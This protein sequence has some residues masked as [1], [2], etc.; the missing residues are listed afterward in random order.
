MRATIRFFAERLLNDVSP[1]H[2]EH[3][4]NSRSRDARRLLLIPRGSEDFERDMY[5]K[6]GYSSVEIDAS[7]SKSTEGDPAAA[8]A[9]SARDVVLPCRVIERIRGTA[10][11]SQRDYFLVTAC[12]VPADDADRFMQ[13][14]ETAAAYMSV[15]SGFV[16]LRL[17]E[18]LRDDAV[19]RFVNVAQWRTMQEFNEA[20]QAP[21]FKSLIKG[22]FAQ[23]SQIIV[24][25]I[26]GRT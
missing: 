14:F 5:R 23:S 19:F 18:S 17:F 7:P 6:C 20:F 9:C 22:G 15:Q 1:L 4:V 21:A 10:A 3:Q 12:D 11:A 16:R 25:G 13:Q 2:S 24:A 26:A 8:D